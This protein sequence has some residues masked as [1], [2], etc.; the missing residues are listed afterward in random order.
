MSKKIALATDHWGVELKSILVEE[1][2]KMG[3]EVLDLGPHENTSVDYPDYA[4]KVTDA[5]A[6]KKA[7]YGVL[8]CGSGI[9]M[10][11]AANRNPS[12]RAALCRDEEDAKMTRLHNNAN[13]LV[14]GSKAVDNGLA[15]KCLKAF[16]NT[17]FEGGRHKQRV[18]KLSYIYDIKK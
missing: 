10:S 14:F 3:F 9:G 17:E 16:L 2:E 6:D 1:I 7:E 8:I 5:I 11:I 13:V 4:K 18:E 15:I 12:V